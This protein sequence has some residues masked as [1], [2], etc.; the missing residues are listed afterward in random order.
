MQ[1]GGGATEAG[2]AL[3]YFELPHASTFEKTTYRRLQTAVR[4]AIVKISDD[5]MIQAREKEVL[6]TV[7]EQ[8]YDEWKKKNLPANEIKLTASYDM[9]WNKRS[10]GTTYDST[11]GHGFVIGGR[12]KKIMQHRVLS[13]CCS[14]CSI[15]K[16]ENRTPPKHECPQNH[17]GSSKS[18]ECE[19]I[20]RMVIEAYDKLHYTIG[21]IIS[22]DDST[23]KSNLKH[24]FDEKIKK[25]LMSKSD[26]SKTI[27]GHKKAD[28][29]RLPLHI[30]EP[31]FLADFNHRVKVVGKTIYHF[32]KMA[33]KHSNISK[34]TAERVKTNWGSMLKQI[35]HLSWEK[36][37]DKIR[38]RVLAPIEHMYGNHDHCDVSWCPYLKAKME[39]KI[40]N[41]RKESKC[42]VKKRTR[43][44][45]NKCV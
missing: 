35:R 43:E 15:A 3:T 17:I 13:K 32:A 30:L 25:G 7:G 29:G 20:Y 44:N 16:R 12:T 18:M 38:Q 34:G 5:T 42:F 45:M 24:S 41:Q 36:D 2:L 40:M 37:C 23:M 14:K 33:K 8:K 11:S 28:H 6:A 10:S 9:G 27:K 21:T 26:W 22:D 39:K 1:I 19:A 4:P 31:Q